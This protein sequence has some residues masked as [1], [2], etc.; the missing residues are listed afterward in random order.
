MF[1]FLKILGVPIS[2]FSSAF[3]SFSFIGVASLI[4]VSIAQVKLV[5]AS[6]SFEY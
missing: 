4:E 1:S 6:V 5:V 3:C 2:S